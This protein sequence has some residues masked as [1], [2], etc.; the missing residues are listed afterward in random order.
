MSGTIYRVKTEG[1]DYRFV[2]AK[3][4]VAAV[5][6]VAGDYFKA[7]ALKRADLVD[8]VTSGAKVEDA[9]TAAEGDDAPEAGGQSQEGGGK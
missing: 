1:A 5:M 8:L 2:K 9:T 6:F 4:Q 3:S 7:E